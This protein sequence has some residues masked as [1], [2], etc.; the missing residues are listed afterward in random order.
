M[1]VPGEV[2]RPQG[3]DFVGPP[4]GLS[5]Q[6][7]GNRGTILGGSLE[8]GILSE[9]CESITVMAVNPSPASPVD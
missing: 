4:G 1:A 9:G 5:V 6:D 2:D 8:R 3:D 7:S